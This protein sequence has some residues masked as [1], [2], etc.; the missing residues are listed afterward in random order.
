[1]NEYT[2]DGMPTWLAAY[3]SDSTYDWFGLRFYRQAL[4]YLLVRGAEANSFTTAKTLI[5]YAAVAHSFRK[6][7]GLD[8]VE[9]LSESQL[10]QWKS[11]YRVANYLYVVP[12]HAFESSAL[13]GGFTGADTE[14]K[15]HFN[16]FEMAEAGSYNIHDRFQRIYPPQREWGYLLQFWLPPIKYF[17]CVLKIES[18]A[19]GEY[20]IHCY[21]TLSNEPGWETFVQVLAEGLI[22]REELTEIKSIIESQSLSSSEK[23]V[24]KQILFDVDKVYPTENLEYQKGYNLLVSLKRG[25]MDGYVPVTQEDY[26][27]ILSYSHLTNVE[28]GPSAQNWKLLASSLT[29]DIGISRLYTWLASLSHGE[30]IDEIDLENELTEWVNNWQNQNGFYGLLKD[31]I[32][33]WKTKYLGSLNDYRSLFENMLNYEDLETAIDGIIQG[34]I[35][36]EIPFDEKTQKLDHYERITQKYHRFAPQRY[37]KDHPIDMDQP[38]DKFILRFTKSLINNQYKFGLERMGMGQKA[39]QILTYFE[40]QRQYV[41]QVNDRKFKENRGIYDMIGA[42]VSTWESAGIF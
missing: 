17:R 36:A 9:I 24:A 2:H 42:A 21:N 18:C 27:M 10:E 25:S 7:H 23:E 15:D 30:V 34:I 38:F 32:D 13:D 39:K 22:E 41:Y 4:R 28:L 12:R 14:Y 40:D 20:A 11:Y 8:E 3:P 37:F 5:Y 26:G 19:T 1:L 35:I 16:T 33:Q 31:V 6:L 29:F